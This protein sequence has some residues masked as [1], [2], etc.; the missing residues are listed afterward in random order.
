MEHFLLGLLIVIEAS[1]GWYFLARDSRDSREHRQAMLHGQEHITELT[2]E[3]L[4][5]TPRAVSGGG[6]DAAGD[7]GSGAGEP[8]PGG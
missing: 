1:I 7:G 8:G 3:V 4:R 6:D 2:A 5:R